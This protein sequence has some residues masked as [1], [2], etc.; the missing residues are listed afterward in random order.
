MQE[1]T[2]VLSNF[3][4]QTIKRGYKFNK[5]YK[6][7]YNPELYI[8]IYKELYSKKRNILSSKMEE[9]IYKENNILKINIDKL[10]EELRTLTYKPTI[11]QV[12]NVPKSRQVLKN[13][14]F[15]YNLLQN[16]VVKILESIYEPVFNDNSYGFRKNRNYHSAIN[17]VKYNFNKL[18]WWV[19]I[20]IDNIFN[21]MDKK[22]L[23]EILRKKISDER[24]LNLI[25]KLIKAGC[26]KN[27]IKYDF[28]SDTHNGGKLSSILINIYLNELDEYIESMK[29]KFNNHASK[30]IEYIRYADKILLGINSSKNDANSI[31]IEIEYFL[32][33]TLNVNL[34]KNKRSIKNTSV[35]TRFLGFDI[36]ISK[37]QRTN[38]NE[39]FQNIIISL[40]FEKIREIMFKNGYVKETK[41]NRL[42]ATHRSYLLNYDALKILSIYNAEIKKLYDYY[43]IADNAHKLND[44]RQLIRL[45]FL[46]T[47]ANKHKTTPKKILSNKT[48]GIKYMDKGNLGVFYVTKR[49]ETKFKQFYCQQPTTLKR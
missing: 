35:K 45:S 25:S 28:Y 11:L 39:K 6:N 26:I 1:I 27:H 34:V 16:A 32:C 48:K 31:K 4:K 18:K 5:I 21:N 14:Y 2:V 40:P 9:D 17:T 41:D 49:N 20:E 15:K 38:N 13:E 29:I 7:L 37:R 43:Q 44:F 12:D 33:K 10:I 22:I 19:E 23:I 3:S 36:F 24:F 8:N 42:K 30:S 47:L 46:K